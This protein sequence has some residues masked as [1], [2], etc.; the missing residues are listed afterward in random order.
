VVHGRDHAVH[1]RRIPLVGG[2]ILAAAGLAL[3]ARAPVSGSY[4]SD[5]LP[6]MLLFGV[7]GGIVL[8]PLLLAATS[9]I[10]PDDAG[11]ASGAV[12]SSFM[13]GGALSLGVLATVSAARTGSLMTSGHGQLAALN[14]GYHIAFAVGAGLA[15]AAACL[16]PFL[17]QRSSRR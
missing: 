10:P 9:D 16:T 5:V 1:H 3:L 17:G 7:A 13:M 2:L 15:I 6:T 8:N 12:N 14:G 4:T 11:V